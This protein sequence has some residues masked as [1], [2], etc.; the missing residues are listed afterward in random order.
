MYLCLVHVV[1]VPGVWTADDHDREVV[2]GVKTVIAWIVNVNTRAQIKSQFP[3]LTYW[4]FEEMRIL[5][6]P[7]R[8]VDGCGDG[9]CNTCKE[10]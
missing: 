4:R 5:L 9:H 3:L 7:F 10:L 2:A 6:E 1:V 8:K